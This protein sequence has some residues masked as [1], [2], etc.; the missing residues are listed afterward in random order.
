VGSI[1]VCARV[2]ANVCAHVGACAATVEAGV[3]VGGQRLCVCTCVYACVYVRE[4]VRELHPVRA[5]HLLS[6]CLFC[7]SKI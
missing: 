3:V 6:K 7:P 2:Y 1:S 5:P 4:H